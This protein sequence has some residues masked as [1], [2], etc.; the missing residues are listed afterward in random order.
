[1]NHSVGRFG[2]GNGIHTNN[3]DNFWSL[4]KRQYIGTHHHYSVK[5]MRLY[6]DEMCFRQNNRENSDIFEDLLEQTIMKKAS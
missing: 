5:Y 2:A 4:V 1:V 3:I 6:I